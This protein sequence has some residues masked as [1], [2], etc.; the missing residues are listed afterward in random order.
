MADNPE[1]TTEEALWKAIRK[2]AQDEEGASKP[3]NQMQA[4]EETSPP[5]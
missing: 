2:M 5:D 4:V 1:I 3:K